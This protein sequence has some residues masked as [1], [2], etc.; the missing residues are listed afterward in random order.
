MRRTLILV[1]LLAMAWLAPALA[2]QPASPMGGMSMNHDHT[3]MGMNHAGKDMPGKHCTPMIH[4][5]YW[6]DFGRGMSMGMGGMSRSGGDKSRKEQ[7]TWNKE[8]KS[9]KKRERRMR[10]LRLK[11]DGFPPSGGM[12]MAGMKMHAKG[13]S[14]KPAGMPQMAKQS[15][16]KGMNSG[17]SKSAA[18]ANAVYWLET[19][20]RVISRVEAKKPGA[21]RF[22]SLQGGHHKVFSYLDAGV[23][24]GQRRKYFSFYN[25]YGHGDKE[26]KQERPMLHNGGY[27][28]GRPEFELEPLYADDQQAYS[29]QTG[30][31]LRFRVNL[32]G[33]PVKDVCVVMLTEK[34]WRNAKR[35]DKHGEVAFF[36]I[37][38][39]YTDGG[40]RT[41]RRAGKYLVVARHQAAIA[42]EW[43][44][45]V[46]ADTRFT[47]AT[48]L[49]VRPSQ[50]EW[51]SK[52][53][54]FIV[55]A[56]T[57]IAA[58]AAIAV[59]RTR[60]RKTVVA[61]EKEEA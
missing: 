49:R 33:E 43:D 20:D 19:P 30:R 61:G 36:L 37:Q 4:N 27:R 14:G 5:F 10:L 45:R 21:I 7:G 26:T 34:G 44:G 52:S 25:Y 50:L 6:L 59:R 42:G 8:K 17:R 39:R 35:T 9:A 23:R 54:A 41:R 58:G 3:A 55:A 15:R 38:E 22:S 13:E 57:I 11:Q 53:T 24:N 12:D 48:S 47:A 31:S 18:L 28:K 40:W 16:K 1:N 56:F 29:T 46:Y 2:E 51:E 60:R 32:R